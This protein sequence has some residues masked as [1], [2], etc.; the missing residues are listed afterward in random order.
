VTPDPSNKSIDEDDLKLH[1][2]CEWIRKIH[3]T[4]YPAG[5]FILKY[6]RLYEVQHPHSQLKSIKKLN[7]AIVNTV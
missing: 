4:M 3:L 1:D 7:P 2:L 6:H 5:Q